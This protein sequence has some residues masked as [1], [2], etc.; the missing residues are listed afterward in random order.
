MLLHSTGYR[1]V[2]LR[3]S[4]IGV[5]Y[6]RPIFLTLRDITVDSIT[7]LLFL[8]KRVFEKLTMQSFLKW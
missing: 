5:M 7:L 1:R 2:E 4:V 8:D 6:P 3:F